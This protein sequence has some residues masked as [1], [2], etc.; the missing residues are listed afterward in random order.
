[1]TTRPA[2]YVSRAN[3]D[4]AWAQAL[5][6]ALRA[7]G[8]DV[9][10]GAVD[11]DSPLDNVDL[12]SRFARGRSSCWCSRG[13]PS[14]PTWWR[15]RRSWRINCNMPCP[16]ATLSPSRWRRCRCQQ[17]ARI[18]QAVHDPRGRWSNANRRGLSSVDIA[19]DRGGLVTGGSFG[20]RGPITGAGVRSAPPG[21]CR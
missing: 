2:I 21:A 12:R 18:R 11:D 15:A 14:G 4:D 10:V 7:L 8:A 20:E 9:A 19:S 5:A 17:T 1:M 6:R 13:R 3:A 16:A